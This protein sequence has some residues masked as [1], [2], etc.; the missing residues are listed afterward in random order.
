MSCQCQECKDMFIIDII[1]PNE[2]WEK[3]KPINS[4][5]DGGL[6]CPSCIGQKLHNV[7]EKEHN[8]RSFELL[9]K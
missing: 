9:E 4:S 3:I 8:Y 6:L 2:I 1:V 7:I 5:K